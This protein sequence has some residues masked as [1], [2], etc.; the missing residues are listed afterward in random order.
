MNLVKTG[1]QNTYNYK[2]SINGIMRPSTEA[3]RGDT[4]KASMSSRTK[5]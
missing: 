1:K 3:S 2:Q 5:H 4:L